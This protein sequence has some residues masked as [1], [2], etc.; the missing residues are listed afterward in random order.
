MSNRVDELLLKIKDKDFL[1]KFYA[2]FSEKLKQE[3]ESKQMLLSSGK[4]EKFC[5][6]IMSQSDVLD[7]EDVWYYW[8]ETNTKFNFTKNG[9]TQEDCGQ[10][11]DLLCDD[12]FIIHENTYT[13]PENPFAHYYTTLKD[14][15]ID[16]FVMYGQGTSIQVARSFKT[17]D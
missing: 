15:G 14:F 9:I 3:Q 16:L 5:E 13:D 6:Q 8:N 4:V 2:K 10:I 11:L 1:E 12:K 17:Q 7:N